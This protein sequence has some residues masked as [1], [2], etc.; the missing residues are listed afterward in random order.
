VVLAA[1]II[2]GLQTIASRE[3][4]PGEPVV[5]TVG[6]IHGGTKNNVIPD[7]VRLQL[8]VRSY[9][10]QVRR[11]TL[12]A[13]ERIAR[14]QALAAG[15][16][17][18]RM[19]EVKCATNSTR[20]LFNDPALA[21]RVAGVFKACFGETNVV[22]RPPSMGGD[23]FAEYGRTEPKVPIFMF[24]LGAVQPEVFKESERT[25]KPLPS[26]HSAQW[27]PMVEPA[28]K[29]GVAAMTAAVLELMQKKDRADSGA[30]GTL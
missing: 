26:L 24:A 20:S 23:D 1:Q 6:S 16:P 8:T 13:I 21:E 10:D 5:V 19:P 28:L 12:E 18:D 25:G 2:L 7:E 27:A 17:E 30:A 15:M 3:V 22:R 4:Q 9:T 29:T 11:Q 14:G